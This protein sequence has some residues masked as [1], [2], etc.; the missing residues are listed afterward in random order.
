MTTMVGRP[1]VNTD[2]TKANSTSIMEGSLTTAVV[3]EAATAEEDIA[4]H[5]DG[6]NIPPET[7]AADTVATGA[8]DHIY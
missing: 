5:L 7:P 1:R 4:A 8:I 3:T 6:T 2:T